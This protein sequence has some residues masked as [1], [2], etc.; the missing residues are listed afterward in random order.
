MLLLLARFARHCSFVSMHSS[1]RS[2]LECIVGRGQTSDDET[3]DA[4]TGDAGTEKYG[5]LKNSGVLEHAGL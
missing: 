5:K 4:E 1:A 2:A 3:G